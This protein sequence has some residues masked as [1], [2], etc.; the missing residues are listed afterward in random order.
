MYC[1]FC[2]IADEK[3]K[4]YVKYGECSECNKLNFFLKSITK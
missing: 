1:N 3:N 4:W 2:L